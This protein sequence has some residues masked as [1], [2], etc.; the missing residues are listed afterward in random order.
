MSYEIE[1]KGMLIEVSVSGGEAATREYPGSPPEVEQTSVRV[2]DWDE[3]AAWWGAEN[4][5]AP[6]SETI[7]QRLERLSE[8]EW[9]AIEEAAFKAAEKEAKEWDGDIDDF[10]PAE[11]DDIM[12][13]LD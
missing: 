7:E 2:S 10:E 5:V 8:A 11:W 12:G 6:T 9:P 4:K 3:F 1:H 13:E